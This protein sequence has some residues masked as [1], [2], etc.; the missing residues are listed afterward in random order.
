MAKVKALYARVSPRVMVLAVVALMLLLSVMPAA[1]QS[2]TIE[3]DTDVLFSSVN[4]WI[5]TFLPIM[6]IPIGIAVALAILGL[7]GYQIVKAFSGKRN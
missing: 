6:A 2:T 5:T 4:S 3:I 7:I 1:A